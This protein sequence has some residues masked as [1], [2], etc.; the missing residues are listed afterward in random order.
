MP[1][2]AGAGP[3]AVCPGGSFVR[4]AT[5][6]QAASVLREPESPDRTKTETGQRQVVVPPISMGLPFTLMSPPPSVEA[7]PPHQVGAPV[8]P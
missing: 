2:L 3:F 7:T 6:P 5:G 1:H 4:F 8:L